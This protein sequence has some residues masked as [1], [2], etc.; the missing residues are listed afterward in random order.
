MLW[1][2]AAVLECVVSQSAAEAHFQSGLQFARNKEYGAAIIEFTN[3]LALSPNDGR[4]FEK[5]ANVL[6]LL[7]EHRSAINDYTKAIATDAG[8]PA[9]FLNRGVSYARLGQ[10]EQAKDD[11]DLCLAIDSSQWKAIE[12]RATALIALGRG[13]EALDDCNRLVELA[14]DSEKWQR[15][16]AVVRLYAGQIDQA[17]SDIKKLVQMDNSNKSEYTAL[18]GWANYR[19]GLFEKSMED[20]SNALAMEPANKFAL[21]LRGAAKIKLGRKEDA[22]RDFTLSIGRFPSDAE[23][24]ELHDALIGGERSRSFEGLTSVLPVTYDIIVKK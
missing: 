24:R 8:N 13:K 16:R 22:Q 19:N 21:V 9:L 18:L 23:L 12:N 14:T 3:T 7:G 5:R 17:I 6:S 10:L 11:F 4:A 20:C 2:C 1:M 15:A